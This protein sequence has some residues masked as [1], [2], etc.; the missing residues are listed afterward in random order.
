MR[1]V[2]DYGLLDFEMLDEKVGHTEF[3]LRP[4]ECPKCGQVEYPET[5]AM[6]NEGDKPELIF[7]KALGLGEGM[8]Q[9]LEYAQML[10]IPFVYSSNGDGFIEHDRMVTEGKK[11]RVL[12]LDE[13]PSSDELWKRYRQ[14]RGID[15]E[16][17]RMIAQ[18]YMSMREGRK[19]GI[20]NESQSIE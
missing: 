20:I 15:D 16:K 2:H 1:K 12:T 7:R 6:Y 14:W 18:P 9:V 3:E 5:L 8:Q 11:E 17:E 19:P 10:D 13:F 4:F